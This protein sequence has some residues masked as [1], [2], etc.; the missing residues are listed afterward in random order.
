MV[1]FACPLGVFSVVRCLLVDG[2]T[3]TNFIGEREGELSMV[4]LVRCI[5]DTRQNRS[6][7][8]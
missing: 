7:F 6:R 2:D 4:E 1:D 3:S 5:G 8:C